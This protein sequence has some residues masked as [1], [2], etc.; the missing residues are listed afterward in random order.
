MQKCQ[1]NLEMSSF[2]HNRNVLFSDF[3]FYGF[4]SL[5]FVNAKFETP[6]PRVIRGR[7]IRFSDS[8]N[9]GLFF[10]LFDRSRGDLS[11][12]QSLTFI[13]HHQG[14]IK[15]IL[16]HH[17]GSPHLVLDL[18]ELM[19]VRHGEVISQRPLCLDT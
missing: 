3:R 18:K 1:A 19:I 10:L 5:I 16:D 11:E 2:Y 15:P 4:T 8:D 12:S 6:P 7:R 13:G 14:T 9:H 17:L